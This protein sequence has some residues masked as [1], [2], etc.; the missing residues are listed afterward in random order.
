[1]T[2]LT[3]TNPATIS[4]Q[5]LATVINKSSTK[6]FDA[7]WH[8][9]DS[10]RNA[11]AEYENKHIPGALFFDIDAI[12]DP[13]AASPHT[14]PDERTFQWHIKAL[15]INQ[16]DTIIFYDNSPLKSSARAW[17]MM[18]LM[19]HKKVSVLDGGLNAWINAG[20]PT[21]NNKVQPQ[22]GNFE[23]N[24]QPHL[25]RH[26]AAMLENIGSKE[27]TVVDARAAER[28]K[29]TAPEP[30]PELAAGHIPNALNV[31]FSSL[32]TEDNKLKPA[33]DLRKIFEGA[34]V[35]INN[36]ITT[37]CG[38][39]VTACNLAHALYTLGNESVAV[40]DGSWSEWGARKDLP[41]EKG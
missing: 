5:S 34:G 16:T 6:I 18:R 9:P 25:I 32:Y 17:W 15:G 13:E 8:M 37:S 28:F 36:R 38:S 33:E 40:Y 12:A 26:V 22:K 31:P 14:M 29:G 2:E 7:S 24:I 10:G 21:D 30:R 27:W 20:Q 35:N 3:M 23:A 11:L 4:V 1:M 39:G 41:I 19:G